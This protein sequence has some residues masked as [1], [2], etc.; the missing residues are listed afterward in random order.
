M[1]LVK[2]DGDLGAFF[3][4]D[5]SVIALKNLG[6]HL[7]VTSIQGIIRLSLNDRTELTLHENSRLDNSEREKPEADPFVLFHL[8]AYPNNPDARK[9]IKAQAKCKK[10]M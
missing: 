9:A 1:D 6:D 5:G 4:K 7:E 2:A 3:L 10:A 8:S